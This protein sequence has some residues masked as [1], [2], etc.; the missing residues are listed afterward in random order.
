L[1]WLLVVV[2]ILSFLGF[3]HFKDEFLSVH[4]HVSESKVD[5]LNL[6]IIQGERLSVDQVLD[7]GDLSDQVFIRLLSI[8]SDDLIKVLVQKVVIDVWHSS[9]TW[10]QVQD[11]AA[12]L[13]KICLDVILLWKGV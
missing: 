10:L 3:V 8:I 9:L 1:H 6:S 7:H 4:A 12:N 11:S 2:L 13:E 5:L